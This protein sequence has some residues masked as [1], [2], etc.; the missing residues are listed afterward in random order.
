MIEL[1]NWRCE[2]HDN[3]AKAGSPTDPFSGISRAN[4]LHSAAAH[5]VD[6]ADEEDI[7]PKVPILQ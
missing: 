7:H 1:Y 4:G 3:G 2:N 5:P 6:S